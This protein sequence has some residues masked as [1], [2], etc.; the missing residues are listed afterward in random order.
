MPSAP[1]LPERCFLEHLLTWFPHRPDKEN[2]A[3]RVGGSPAA[4]CLLLQGVHPAAQ[5]QRLRGCA[6]PHGVRVAG[7]HQ[8]AAVH[9][10]LPGGWLHHHREGGADDQRVSVSWPCPACPRRDPRLPLGLPP[11]HTSL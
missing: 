2:K 5:H 6:L 3:G 8:D 4:W 9:G 10:A 7:V 1:D 11:A